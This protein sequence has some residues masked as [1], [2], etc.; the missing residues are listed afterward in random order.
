MNSNRNSNRRRG[1]GNNRTGNGGSHNRIDSRA[2]S[3]APQMLE[4]Y[5]KLANDASLNDDRVQTEY[6]LQF[7]DHYFRVIADMKAPKDETRARRDF[8]RDLDQDLDRD[9]EDEDEAE[10]ERPRARR[11]HGRREADASREESEAGDQGRRAADENAEGGRNPFLVEP[12]AARPRKPARR[13]PAERG[14]Q[15]DDPADAEDAGF[16]PDL[17]PPAILRADQDADDDRGQRDQNGAEAGAELSPAK[18]RKPARQPR[19]R[20]P[21]A[22]RNDGESKGD[23]EPLEAVG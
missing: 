10:D 1:R 2:R 15:G 17:L 6:Y 3:N 23:D 12:R 5:R 4:K 20:R 21:R 9:E 11:E 8:D 13:W 14:Q 22:P 19:P 16:N 18:E 7:A